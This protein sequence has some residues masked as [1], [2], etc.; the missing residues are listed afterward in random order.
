MPGLSGIGGKPAT[1]AAPKPE[2]AKADLP[3]QGSPEASQPAASPPA[4]PNAKPEAATESQQIDANLAA[5]TEADAAV[6]GIRTTLDAETGT[7]GL[8]AALDKQPTA[9]TGIVHPTAEQLDE[10]LSDAE[11]GNEDDD[12][13]IYHYTG[14]TNFRAGPYHF[15]NGQLRLAA[16]KVADFERFYKTLPQIEQTRIVKIDVEA[17]NAMV[18]SRVSGMKAGIDTTANTIETGGTIK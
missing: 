16:D 4:N 6:A 17:A 11:A 1:E 13:V 3:K 14:G 12:S 10:M 8:V 7:V 5:A 9:D 15:D 2:D 18:A